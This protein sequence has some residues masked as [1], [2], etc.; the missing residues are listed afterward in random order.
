MA[1]T[2]K[3]LV[4]FLQTK[5]EE[6]IARFT[7]LINCERKGVAEKVGG[8]CVMLLYQYLDKKMDIVTRIVGN[9][10]PGNL[11]FYDNWGASYYIHMAVFSEEGIKILA[12]QL[13]EFA[14]IKKHKLSRNH[15]NLELLIVDT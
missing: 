2:R 15:D 3:E 9:E 12:D 5:M 11:Y 10:L 7:L 6:G 4:A 14:K 8:D 1:F 13:V